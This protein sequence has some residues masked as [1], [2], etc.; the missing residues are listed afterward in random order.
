MFIEMLSAL[1]PY[2]RVIKD[3][4]GNNRDSFSKR[5]VTI[6]G[7]AGTGKSSLVASMPY[8]L[9]PIDSDGNVSDVRVCVLNARMIGE[10]PINIEEIRVGDR[11]VNAAEPLMW[12]PIVE[13]I[14]HAEQGG[15]SVLAIEELYAL[16]DHYAPQLLYPLAGMEQMNRISAICLTN[17]QDYYGESL[18]LY[19]NLAQRFGYPIKDFE[20]DGMVKKMYEMY[21][22][23]EYEPIRIPAVIEHDGENRR[24]CNSIR[25]LLDYALKGK[26]MDQRSEEGK[27][28][29][30]RTLNWCAEQLTAALA[31]LD[32]NE[33]SVWDNH[34]AKMVNEWRESPLIVPPVDITHGI[35][36]AR[37]GPVAA[38]EVMGVLSGLKPFPTKEFFQMLAKASQVDD[39]LGMQL[40]KFVRDYV[41][42]SPT[43]RLAEMQIL[44]SVRNLV[45]STIKNA[46]NRYA[47]GETVR[48]QQSLKQLAV[49]IDRL[50]AALGSL[51]LSGKLAPSTQTLLMGVLDTGIASVIARPKDVAGIP[52]VRDLVSSSTVEFYAKILSK[53][54]NSKEGN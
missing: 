45:M 37:L 20:S 34:T 41:A 4:N 13:S 48:G 7:S 52:D 12:K 38:Q 53:R 14:Q 46:Y 31:I 5:I 39:N 21:E 27:W 2:K 54:P 1:S 49:M 25:E 51:A 33:P 44:R 8:W 10:P 6:E 40:D 9:Q 32:M 24:R 15:F 30:P 23:G 18:T 22:Q 36:Q 28:L 11:V 3:A 42:S 29:S 47:D 19:P 16:P 17:P 43:A 26:Y 35:V 50:V